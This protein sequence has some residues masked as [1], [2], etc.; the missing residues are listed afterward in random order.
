M[1]EYKVINCGGGLL[2]CRPIE[3]TEFLA[4]SLTIKFFG[5]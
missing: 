4:E 3:T 2:V 5:N 1:V